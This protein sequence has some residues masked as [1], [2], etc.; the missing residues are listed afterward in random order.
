MT[1][2]IL[3]NAIITL[4]TVGGGSYFGIKGALNG[5][6]SSAARI[7]DGVMNIRDTALE[8]KILLGQHVEEARRLAESV[9]QEVRK[10]A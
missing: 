1:V 9:R 3:I 4:V 8:T 5:L 2:E 10:G 7:E 6:R